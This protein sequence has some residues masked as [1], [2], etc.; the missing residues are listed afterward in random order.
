MFLWDASKQEAG[1]PLRVLEMTGAVVHGAGS[2]VGVEGEADCDER[3]GGGAG[4]GAAGRK[5]E[6]AAGDACGCLKHHWS[7]YTQPHTGLACLPLQ[8]HMLSPAW[9]RRLKSDA[10]L[11]LRK[12]VR[13]ILWPQHSTCTPGDASSCPDWRAMPRSS[14]ACTCAADTSCWGTCPAPAAAAAAA[15]DVEGGA[16][17][18]PSPSGCRWCHASVVAAVVS[19]GAV[20]A[21]AAAAAAPLTTSRITALALLDAAAEASWAWQGGREV[22]GIG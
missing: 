18:G 19:V 22:T 15:A 1:Y 20:G 5:C 2:G 8:G 3:G 21:V 13:C 9:A 11:C 14:C 6:D 4:T 16:A 10:H 12:Q 7:A 17:A